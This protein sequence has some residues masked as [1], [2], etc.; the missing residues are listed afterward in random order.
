MLK[1]YRNPI[2]YIVSMHPSLR[3]LIGLE[4]GLSISRSDLTSYSKNALLFWSSDDKQSIVIR[5]Y[6]IIQELR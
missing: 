4:N 2:N 5:Q 1:I 6:N 3:S